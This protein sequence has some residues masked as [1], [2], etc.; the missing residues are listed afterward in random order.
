M[1]L[2][3]TKWRTN[4]STNF[5]V[6]QLFASTKLIASPWA[7]LTKQ[8]Y[9]QLHVSSRNGPLIC[10]SNLLVLRCDLQVKFTIYVQVNSQVHLSVH[11][12]VLFV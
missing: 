9:K 8:T 6:D 5:F 4:A 10:A 1:L 2:T 3:Q 11:I 12:S 7:G